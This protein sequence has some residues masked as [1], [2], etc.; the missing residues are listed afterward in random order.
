GGDWVL[1]RRDGVAE[2]DIRLTLRTDDG[3]LIYVRCDGIFD[4]APEVRQRV[5]GGEDVDPSEYYFRTTPRF[6][7]G[8][9]KYRW[10][11]RLVAIGVGRRTAT[12]MVTDVFAV[13]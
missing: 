13:G 7:T 10:L 1:L 2:L 8:S 5:L 6:E 12:G 4:M 11:N 3:E 9:E